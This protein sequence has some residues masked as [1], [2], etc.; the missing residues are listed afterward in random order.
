MQSDE[1]QASTGGCA[2]DGIDPSCFRAVMFCPRVSQLLPLRAQR[3]ALREVCRWK[4]H[5]SQEETEEALEFKAAGGDLVAKAARKA[6]PA[7][8]TMKKTTR[9]RPGVL[10]LRRL[11]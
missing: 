10:A 4:G 2:A 3:I 9:Y 8:G 11:C 7:V 5:Q 1:I 6:A